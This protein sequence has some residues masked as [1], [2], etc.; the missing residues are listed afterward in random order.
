MK[1]ELRKHKDSDRRKWVVTFVTFLLVIGLAGAA[2]A[3]AAKTAGWFE[4]RLTPKVSAFGNNPT[5]SDG[6]KLY[7]ETADADGNIIVS[8]NKN[9]EFA[10]TFNTAASTLYYAEAT[11]YV[12]N[13]SNSADYPAFGLAHYLALNTN[14]NETGDVYNNAG[15]RLGRVCVASIKSNSNAKL[16]IANLTASNPQWFSGPRL[17]DNAD[18]CANT[19]TTMTIA[20]ARSGD[21]LYTYVNDTLVQAIE[22]P[23]NYKGVATT[24]GII[25]I[26]NA[27]RFTARNI[28][29][30]SA[31]AAQAK[32]TELTPVTTP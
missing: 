2:F 26:C 18:Y 17:Y 31:D 15:T 14:V 19:F 6:S 5:L 20:I 1:N 27:N 7:T 21:T 30:L 3:L 13:T 24:P 28:Q 25:T 29:L 23:A 12:P 8:S 11:F 9:G 4:P 32:I 10:A 22:A 16:L